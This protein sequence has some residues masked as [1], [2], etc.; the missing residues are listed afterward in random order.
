MSPQNPAAAAEGATQPD[1]V[2]EPE[3]EQEDP[4][5]QPPVAEKWSEAVD[6][7]LEATRA[8]FPSSPAYD[9]AEP[10][11]FQS[12]WRGVF[13]QLS[14]QVT[15]DSHIPEH[16][17]SPPCKE[18][19]V[20]VF[21]QGAG[22]EGYPCPCCLPE[23][24]PSVRLEN[25]AGVTKGDLIRGLGGF[26]YGEGLPRVYIEDGE[27]SDVVPEGEGGERDKRTGVLVHGAD[28]MS[29]GGIEGE[30]GE[31][32]VYTGGWIGRPAM[33]W[34]YC[35]QPG[36]FAEKAAAKLRDGAGGE[37]EPGTTMARL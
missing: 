20:N 29:E 5:P 1:L 25:E 13:A 31:R 37:D 14:R 18:F 28:W 9:A 21:A 30:N 17:T 3:V 35:C 23:V 12:Y 8:A 6:A 26:L 15:S 22:D 33:I 34:M 4:D 36:E 32:Y 7:V 24:E 2:G 10:G 27:G 19:V 11:A 16:L